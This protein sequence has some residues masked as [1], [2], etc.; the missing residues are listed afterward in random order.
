MSGQSSFAA[1][2]L[3]DQ[4][5]TPSGLIAWNGSD[6]A[7]RFAVYRNNV[8]VSLID[9]LADSFPVTHALVGGEFFSGMARIFAQRH[10]PASPVLAFYGAGFADFIA[11]FEPV[12]CL[13]Y[14]PDV[15]RLE[16]LY[17]RAYHAADAAPLPVEALHALLADEARLA[18]AG[19][20]LHPSL[21]VLSSRYAVV[22]LWG[23]HQGVQQGEDGDRT[24]A[25][26]DLSTLDTGQPESAIVCRSGP[27]GLTVEVTVIPDSAAIFISG[28][29]NGHTLAAA[30]EHA[31]AS[32]ADEFSLVDC[33]QLL[34]RLQLIT[35]LTA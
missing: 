1:A 23:A 29:R 33:L 15:A 25:T 12:A 3:S 4:M 35:G 26:V 21:A 5:Q 32:S 17:V 11:G 2:L 24:G 7:K 9:A 6:P 30:A 8:M 31:A 13:P 28:L 34:I 19:L 22:S 14:L 16:Y 20:V 18:R 27:E 10:P